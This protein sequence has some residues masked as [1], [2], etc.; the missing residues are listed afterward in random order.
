MQNKYSTNI[1]VS[2]DIG[3]L[4]PRGIAF[5]AAM[6]NAS[7][8]LVTMPMTAFFS[9]LSA[10]FYT[11]KA[12]REKSG[13]S[14]AKMAVE[15][16]AAAGIIAAI[17]VG[18]TVGV[19][20]GGVI[21]GGIFAAKG[22]FG[23]GSAA[24]FGIKAASTKSPEE[25]IE[26][27]SKAQENALDGA[28]NFL[29]GAGLAAI[30]IFAGPLTSILIGVGGIVVSM[31]AGVFY[32]LLRFERGDREHAAWKAEQRKKNDNV[33]A[34]DLTTKPQQELTSAKDTKSVMQK[35]GLEAEDNEKL[36]TLPAAS[37]VSL[38]SFE[39][40]P[41]APTITDGKGL[42]PKIENVSAADSVKSEFRL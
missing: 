5:F 13:H 14:F 3:V 23:F 19:A 33:L 30:N 38:I 24:Y 1:E 22:L 37:N 32:P 17:V 10:W 28:I 39:E 31:L 29:C 36:Q 34:A 15:I 6:L 11:H 41:A 8:F 12:I 21:F 40:K 2:A 20:F 42:Y 4:I 18:F 7:S 35:L 26:F 9:V 16:L 27:T 25:R